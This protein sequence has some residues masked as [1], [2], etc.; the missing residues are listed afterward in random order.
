MKTSM[1]SLALGIALAMGSGSAAAINVGGVIWNPDSFFDFTSTDSMIE[2]GAVKVGDELN[3]YAQIDKINGT[4]NSVFCPT[5]EVTYVFSGYKV[6]SIIAGTLT[7]SG[8]TINVYV[9]NTP[10]FDPLLQSTA[11]DGTLFLSLSAPTFYDAAANGG[12]GGTGSL[13]STP[14]PTQ[15]GVSGNGRGFL[16][17]TGGLAAANFDT[18]TRAYDTDGD[19][20]ADSFAD[21]QFTSSFQLLP[22]AFT[23]DNGITYN[24]F[25]SN[26]LQGNSIPEPGSLALLGI[27]LAGLGMSFRRRKSA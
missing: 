20:V 17:V 27:G 22:T 14:T 13:F 21:L 8:G 26:D 24:L 3:G 25:G 10:N 16:D 23:S 18:N 5:C 15:Q 19:G 2:L 12:A 1:K 11:A 7:F 9:D 4:N 6:T